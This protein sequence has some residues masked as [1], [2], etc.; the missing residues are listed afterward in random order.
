LRSFEE[1]GIPELEWPSQSP[2]LNPIENLWSILERACKDRRP[3]TAE[4]LFNCLKEAW[5]ALPVDLLERLA[6][7]MPRRCQE[8]IDND[9]YPCKY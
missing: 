7:S 9:G 8:V 1:D 3:N 5:R 6:C 2:Y 4:E